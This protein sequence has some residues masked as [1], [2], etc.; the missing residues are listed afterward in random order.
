M[1]KLN[2]SKA[3]HS[4][5]WEPVLKFNEMA[6]ITIDWY[7]LYYDNPKKIPEMTDYQIKYYCKLA[8]E[9]KSIWIK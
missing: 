2:C 4:L 8:N 6:K 1:L 7:K 3:L 9:K 5:K